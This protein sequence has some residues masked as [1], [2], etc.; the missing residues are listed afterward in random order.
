MSENKYLGR[1]IKEQHSFREAGTF[2]SLY[3][4]QR[5]LKENGYEY[6][7]LCKNEPVGIK[8]GIYDLPE[9]YKN[10]DAHDKASVDGWMTSVDF[11]ESQVIIYIFN[12]MPVI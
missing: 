1:I 8:A 11:R 2:E 4:A 12:T 7:S 5:W 10:M 3:A 6:G 9:K